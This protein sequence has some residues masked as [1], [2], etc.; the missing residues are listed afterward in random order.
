MLF[1]KK[2]KKLFD[3]SFYLNRQMPGQFFFPRSKLIPCKKKMWAELNSLDWGSPRWDS[4]G[5]PER[6]SIQLP[7]QVHHN[8]CLVV[9]RFSE[10]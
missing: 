8:V 6:A 5:G 9:P 3:F 4:E 7:L 2:K 1:G 10:H